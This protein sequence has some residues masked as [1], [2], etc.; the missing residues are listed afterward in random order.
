MILLVGLIQNQTSAQEFAE[1]G[2]EDDD[3]DEDDDDDDDANDLRVPIEDGWKM[4]YRGSLKI[5]HIQTITLTFLLFYIDSQDCVRWYE[6]PAT[7]VVYSTSDYRK[8][9]PCSPSVAEFYQRIGIE[10]SIW[11]TVVMHSS[12]DEREALTSYAAFLDA[13]DA[14]G[15][16]EDEE[17]AYLRELALHKLRANRTIRTCAAELAIGLAALRLP[18]LQLHALLTALCDWATCVPLHVR[19]A[20]LLVVQRANKETLK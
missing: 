18:L 5:I 20:W 15:L 12:I 7:G 1:Y 2:D 14:S 8:A 6:N 13:V 19:E 10:N 9:L 3:E 11:M 16:E 17:I 4:I